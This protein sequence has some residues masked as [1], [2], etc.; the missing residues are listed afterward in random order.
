MALCIKEHLFSWTEKYD[1]YDENQS[2]LYSVEGEFWSLGHKIHILDAKGE[3]VAYIHEK[4]WAFFK[5]FEIYLQGEKKGTLKEKFSWFHPK[6]Q[7]DFLNCEITGDIFGW[8]YQMMKGAMPMAMIQ[9]KIFSWGNVFYLSYPDPQ[10]EL[11]VLTLDLAIDA[12]H[13]DDETAEIIA[14]SGSYH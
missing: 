2:V 8:N 1:V 5:T 3:E 14:V 4:V 6:Y 11:A 9:R 7:V 13:Q 12:A 10:D